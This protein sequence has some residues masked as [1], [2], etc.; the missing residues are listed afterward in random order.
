MKFPMKKEARNALFIIIGA[1]LFII[2]M[3]F[4]LRL[5]QRELFLN[6]PS[7]P[8][9]YQVVYG[10]NGTASCQAYCEGIGGGPWNGELPQNWNGANCQDTIGG[11]DCNTI[12]GSPTQCICAQ[13]GWGWSQRGWRS[14]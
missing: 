5:I 3:G 2:L 8:Y 7:S 10:D 11:G 4:I 14:R 13:S 12:K 6:V 1:F 9:N